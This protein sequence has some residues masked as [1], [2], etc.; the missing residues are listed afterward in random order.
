ME[1]IRRYKRLLAV[2]LFLGL[3]FAIFQLSGLRDNFSLAFLQ[4]R[5]IENKI[6][7]QIV[8]AAIEVH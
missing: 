8:D 2:V 3:L 5:I 6:S 4:H 1:L 7:G